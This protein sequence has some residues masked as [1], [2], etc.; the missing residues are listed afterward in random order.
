MCLLLLL[1]ST[2]PNDIC[3]ALIMQ[4]RMWWLC[5]MQFVVVIL[6]RLFSFSFF[7]FFY[8]FSKFRRPFEMVNCVCGQ[9]QMD[10]LTTSWESECVRC[11]SSRCRWLRSIELRLDWLGLFFFFFAF[12]DSFRF[13]FV[14]SDCVRA[15]LC[16]SDLCRMRD[17]LNF[18]LYRIWTL[19]QFFFF[20]SFVF[21]C[22]T[23][24][25]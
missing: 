13:L 15:R 2:I 9:F 14:S 17:Y 24:S 18:S 22:S 25:K 4:F 8:F 11:C 6:F 23:A 16:S 10:G 1:L 12:I 7:H 3:Y 5:Q 19:C 21:C 20:N